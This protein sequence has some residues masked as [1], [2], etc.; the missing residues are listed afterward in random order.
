MVAL[1]GTESDT[2]L[3]ARAVGDLVRRTRFPVA[4]GGL[5]RDD[6]I[7]VTSVFGARTRSLDGL[8][9]RSGRGLG[10]KAL[11]ERRPRVALDY[12]SARGITHDYD[13]PV[14]GEGIATLFA[15]PIVVAE[16]TRGVLYCGSWAS[17]PI[18]DAVA[19][20]ALRVADEVAGELRVRD[21]VERRLSAA[22]P[23]A[24]ASVLAPA[25]QDE[26][27]ETYAEL[28]G[29]AASV[30]DAALRERLA[31]V[32]QRLAS[33]SRSG[34]V[35][36]SDVRLSPREIDVL[37]CAALGA[38]NSEIAESLAL[39]E[40]TVKSYLQAAMAKLDAS[41]RHAAVLKARRA[42]LLP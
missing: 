26:L 2:Q 31:R 5:A 15:V 7:H 21:E 41:T 10:G 8:V 40:A 30:T 3:I 33:L 29:I 37:A 36:P 11:L 32:E 20:P 4:F 23:A 35:A 28:R 22:R 25:V 19:A 9:V 27:R 18:G 6:S 34:D 14:L 1:A 42:G 12:R 16:R 38:T 13:G 24:E 39:K 17:A